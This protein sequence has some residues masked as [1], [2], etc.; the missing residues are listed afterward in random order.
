[1]QIV[2]SA[3]GCLSAFL[4]G[5]KALVTQIGSFMGRTVVTIY[6]D[7]MKFMQD[8]Q[9]ER[10]RPQEKPV[11]RRRVRQNNGRSPL[12]STVTNFARKTQPGEESNQL[13]LKMMPS[14]RTASHPT[15]K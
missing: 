12:L 5:A 8:L 11:V 2:E 3:T 13:I 1:M 14:S 10:L 6:G 4:R 15:K 7:C 9:R